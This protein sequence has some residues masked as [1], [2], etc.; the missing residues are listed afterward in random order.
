MTDTPDVTLTTVAGAP[1]VKIE[2]ARGVVKQYLFRVEARPGWWCCSLRQSGGVTYHV[3]FELG[4]WR[5]SCPDW[6]YRPDR[7]EAP[8]KH[9]RTAMGLKELIE[10]MNT[11]IEP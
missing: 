1:A 6:K 5:C 10:S 7:V 8:C 2:G 11:D 9:V 3:V 4:V